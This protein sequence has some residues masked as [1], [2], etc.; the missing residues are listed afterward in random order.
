MA[1]TG[2]PFHISTYRLG[3]EEPHPLFNQSPNGGLIIYQVYYEPYCSI[4]TTVGQSGQWSFFYTTFGQWSFF[5]QSSLS[6]SRLTRTGRRFYPQRSSSGQA[7]VTGG[8][9]PFSP[10]VRAFIFSRA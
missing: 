9:R 3:Q 5:F 8:C 10:S 4:V 2:I 6:L 1:F 7:V